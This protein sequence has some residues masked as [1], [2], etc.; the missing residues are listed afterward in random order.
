MKR[1][2]LIAAL[3]GILAAERPATGL[4]QS[5]ASAEPAI[6]LV[7]L[8]AVDQFRSDYLS[9]FEAEYKS[10]I[11]RLLTDGAVF[12]SAK[13]EHY[14]TVTAVGHASMLSGAIPADSG[15]IGNDWFDR[16]SGTVVTSVFDGTVQV[17]GGTDPASAAS[18]R[19]LLVSTIGDELKL[20]RSRTGAGPAP[21]VIGV[22]LKD[23]SA[24]L[25][26]GRGGDA[27]YWFD[28]TT[29]AFLSS[30][31]YFPA[32]PPWVTA[33]NARKL[34]DGFAGKTWAFDA[35]APTRPHVM[36]AT[37]GEPLYDAVYGSPFGNDLLLALATETLSQE[38][39]GQ[40]GVTDVFSVSFSSNDSVGHT[41]GPDSPEVHDI[42]VKTDAV[43]G[44][45]LAEVDKRVGLARTLVMFTSDHGVAPVPESMQQ[46]RMAGGRTSGP[47]LFDPMRRALEGRFGAGKWVLATA[48]SSPYLNY[49]LIAE[50]KLDPAEVRRVAADAAR[51]AAGAHVARV[52]TR[53]QLL[54]A[55]IQ[56]DVIGRRVL[57][58]FNASRSGDL[59]IVLEPNWMRSATGTTHGTPYDYDA[60]V[61]LVLMGPGIRPGRYAGA[62]A[63]N[64]AAPTI[65]TILN[66]AAP[67][68]SVGRV[69][70]EALELRATPT[71]G[72]TGTRGQAR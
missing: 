5:A 14:P 16:E 47:T 33:F 72:S 61:P 51:T 43:I 3:L 36:P 64:D 13:L 21:K 69:L 2:F 68:A 50:K 59:E 60:A 71:Q 42:S 37:P 10:G 27:S 9:R 41:Y 55:E 26:A 57:R 63:L 54:R 45:L 58:G 8:I 12:T 32:M 28:T 24:I 48:G 67:N 35:G 52:Y 62:V 46:R 23:R 18:P 1:V 22:S 31:Y 7:L 30:T 40:R 15:I 38:Q 25:P 6:K 66:I 29:G 49:A 34:A 39:L 4:A 56:D 19:R 17:L 44:N 20:A 53:D 70:T 65:S 11:R